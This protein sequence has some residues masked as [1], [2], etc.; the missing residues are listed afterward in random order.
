MS[1]AD[2]VDGDLVRLWP[3]VGRGPRRDGLF[4]LWL[5]LRVALDLTLDP[6]LGERAAR[7]RQAALE[8]RLSSLTLPPPLRR[9][10]TA[11]LQQIRED[12]ATGL[13]VVLANLVAPV[14][15]AAGPEA[16]DLVLQLARQARLRSRTPSR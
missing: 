16:A 8:R 6:P 10:L 12:G 2:A 5:T 15:E 13:P 11:A 1:E 14:R 7:R 9:A 3:R 4:A